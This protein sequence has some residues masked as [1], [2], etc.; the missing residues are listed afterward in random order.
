MVRQDKCVIFWTMVPVVEGSRK[1]NMNA[2][3]VPLLKKMNKLYNF[4]VR[5]YVPLFLFPK[6]KLD[7]LFAKNFCHFVIYTTLP[8]N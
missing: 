8:Y 4:C 6:E 2:F 1:I 7:N 3:R 5:I